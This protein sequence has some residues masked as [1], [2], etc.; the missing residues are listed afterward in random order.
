MNITTPFSVIKLVFILS[1]YSYRVG[2]PYIQPCWSGD[3]QEQDSQINGSS[4][5]FLWFSETAGPSIRIS[6]SLV[7]R[8]PFFL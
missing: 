7:V 1:V 2:D 8:I 6:D 5:P 3:Q 4:N